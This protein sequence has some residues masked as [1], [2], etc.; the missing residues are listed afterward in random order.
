MPKEDFLSKILPLGLGSYCDGKGGVL[1]MHLTENAERPFVAVNLGSTHG[2][3][4]ILRKWTEVNLWHT[5]EDM[6]FESVLQPDKQAIPNL[7]FSM[8]LEMSKFIELI[9]RK[10]QSSRVG[11]RKTM[12]V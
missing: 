3:N 10:L 7:V 5:A 2:L 4:F 9:S 11:V 8:M 6:D 12:P 1:P